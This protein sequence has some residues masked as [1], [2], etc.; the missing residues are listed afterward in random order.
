VALIN[1]LLQHSNQAIQNQLRDLLTKMENHEI[2]LLWI[3]LPHSKRFFKNE[4]RVI[5]FEYEALKEETSKKERVMEFH[6][7]PYEVF[8]VITPPKDYKFRKKEIEYYD[9]HSQELLRTESNWKNLEGDPIYLNESQ[10]SVTVRVRPNTNQQILFT[11]SFKPRDTVIAFPKL[12]LILLI[13]GSLIIAYSSIDSYPEFCIKTKS[14]WIGNP[15]LENQFQ[16]GIGIIGAALVIPR[17]INNMDIRD[18]LRFYFFIP[19]I[20]AGI[21][22]FL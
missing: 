6:S 12:A 2:Y 19:I 17:L 4:T 21:S 15:F 9:P 18:S 16:V 5:T 1:N 8:Y 22:L 7:A 11:Y 10:N 13:A 14:C 20:I 3:K